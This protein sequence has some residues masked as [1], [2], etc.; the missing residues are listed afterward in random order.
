M[1]LI[2]KIKLERSSSK[3]D[4]FPNFQ[5]RKLDAAHN[6]VL[7]QDFSPERIPTVEDFVSKC[8]ELDLKMIIDLK[9]WKI[10]EKT[11]EFVCDLYTKKPELYAKVKK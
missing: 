11:V 6:H 5:L 8:L 10:P 2:G 7:K 9:S 4:K 3:Y 1:V